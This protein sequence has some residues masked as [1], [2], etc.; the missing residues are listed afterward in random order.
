VPVLDEPKTLTWVLVSCYLGATALFFA[1]ML[2][3][4]TLSRLSFLMRG[5]TVAAVVAAGAGI[6]GYFH[7]VPSLSDLFLLYG[8]ARGTF[9]DP[10]VLGA[11]L[12]LPGLVAFQRVLSGGLGQTVRAGTLLMI[13]VAGLLLSFSRG[14][15]GQFAFATAIMMALT[16]ITSRSVRE[17]G[18]I[19][20]IA[21]FGALALAALL[22]ALLSIPQV[23]DL[24]AQ[25]A[26][27]E[28]SY[29]TGYTG[30][31]GR[32]I[33]GALLALDKPFGI[34]P[35]QFRTIFPEDPHNA[36]LNAFM[37]GGWMSGIAYLTLT[38]VTVVRGFR[39]A[40]LAL[41]WQRLY[42]AVY[43]AYLGLVA[44]SFII[45]SDHWRHYFLVL[46]VLWGLMTISNHYVVLAR[47]APPSRRQQPARRGLAPAM[48]AA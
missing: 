1:A 8:R 48:P 14:A 42:I 31:F 13:I 38:V 23:S 43:S 27:L 40:F 10:N 19:V 28:Q 37:S 29:D 25:R 15:W 46:G 22:A 30:R 12:V 36:Y 44:E 17:R 6:L 21:L 41:P 5:Y 16:F 32:H 24:F 26:A 33:L 47:T 34:G 20:I 3:T 45:D 18:R 4:N 2:G 7:I 9:N 35:L 39:F 11:F